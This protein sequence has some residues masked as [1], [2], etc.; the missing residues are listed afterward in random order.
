MRTEGR[1]CEDTVRRWLNASQGERPQN[2]TKP[3]GSLLGLPATRIMRNTFL[4]CQPPSRW[5]FVM[6]AL[7]N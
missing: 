1:R 7:E 6:V 3:A 2:E 4:L 5:H